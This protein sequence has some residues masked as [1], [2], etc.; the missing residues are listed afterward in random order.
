MGDNPPSENNKQTNPAAAAPDDNSAITN[1]A[2]ESLHIKPPKKPKQNTVH[3][4]AE[5]EKTQDKPVEPQPD[6][7]LAEAMKLLKASKGLPP[8]GHGD[9]DKPGG[10]VSP[11]GTP[12]PEG[13]GGNSTGDGDGDGAP[14]KHKKGNFKLRDRNMIKRPHIMD[15]S[16]EEGIVV[17]DIIVDET[18]RVIKATPG[19]KGTTTTNS[20]LWSKARQASLSDTKFNPHPKGEKEQKG[21]I[22]FTFV[23]N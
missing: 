13:N 14:G 18:G 5:K 9:D 20:V 3:K 6:N 8:G 23:H 7:D 4:T 17:V 16:Q 15:D 2:E 11:D 12:G 10:V 21:T 19:A 22:T 1:D